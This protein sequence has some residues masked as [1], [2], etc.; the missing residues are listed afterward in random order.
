MKYDVM[1]KVPASAIIQVE[2]DTEDEARSII[3]DEMPIP[4]LCHHCADN[5]DM[6]D[7]GVI[8]GVTKR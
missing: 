6:S 4:C 8:I 3:E 2:A 5:F 1:L 7:E